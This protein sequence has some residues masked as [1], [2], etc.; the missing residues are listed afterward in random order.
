MKFC[1]FLEWKSD[2]V[3]IPVTIY[4]IN[5]NYL[6]NVCHYPPLANDQAGSRITDNRQ[7][8]KHLLEDANAAMTNIYI[9]KIPNYAYAGNENVIHISSEFAIFSLQGLVSVL[10]MCGNAGSKI[11]RKLPFTISA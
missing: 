10:L 9:A 7:Q 3:I 5:N 4:W 2:P 8:F 6:S 11:E 1:G